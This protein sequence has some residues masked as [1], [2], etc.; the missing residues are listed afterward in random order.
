MEKLL[1]AKFLEDAEKLLLGTKESFLSLKDNHADA[2]TVDKIYRLAHN[3]KGGAKS[4]GFTKLGDF[5]HFFELLIIKIKRQEIPISPE[6]IE[7]LFR[8]RAFLEKS[9]VELKANSDIELETPAVLA[10][11]EKLIGN[12][13]KK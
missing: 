4:V 8:G 1:K 12:Q 13:D 9:L 5:S 6:A 7:I 10:D 3:F 2:A 11:I